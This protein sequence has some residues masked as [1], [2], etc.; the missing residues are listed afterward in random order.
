ME[1]PYIR[2]LLYYITM[3]YLSESNLEW[4]RVRVVI[5]GVCWLSRERLSN[6]GESDLT[7]RDSFVRPVNVERPVTEH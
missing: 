2:Y 4:S 6:A 7:H 5:L 3:P 1:V